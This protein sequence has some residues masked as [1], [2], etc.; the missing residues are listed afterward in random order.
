MKRIRY[1]TAAILL[2]VFLTTIPVM[3]PASAPVAPADQAPATVSQDI[4]GQDADPERTLELA[5]KQVVARVEGTD[6]TMYQLIGMMNRVSSA[7]YKYVEELT[8]EITLEIKERALDR[9]IFEELAVQSALRQGV[10][11]PPENIEKVIGK[12]KE[13]YETEEG[14]QG[15]LDGVGLTEE[16]MRAKIRRS[17]LFEII[18]GREVYRK[19]KVDEQDY[20]KAYN[21]YKEAG[22]LRTADKFTVKEILL[23]GD[24][25]KE[26]VRAS[27]DRLL[28][29]LKKKDFDFG[30]LMMDGTFIVRR[31]PISK[32]KYP[33]IYGLMETM[34]VGQVSEVVED[35]D[36]FHIF[37]V[38]ENEHARELTEDEA[39]GFLENKLRLPAQEKRRTEW[40]EELRKDAKIEI[41]DEELKEILTKAPKEE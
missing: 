38:L 16:G 9:L 19:V 24:D 23:L 5:K 30:R 21:E 3:A 11:V 13:A 6:I 4:G 34:E 35:G 25:D 12:L 33:V 31:M 10:E 14:F 40:V 32:A 18:T 26:K 15:Y 22:K 20:T 39:R 7:Y 37:K 28:A 27:A 41:L 8:D 2:S 36:T 29:D 17:N 1:T